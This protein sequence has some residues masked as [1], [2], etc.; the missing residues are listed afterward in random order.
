LGFPEIFVFRDP[1]G[2][3]LHRGGMKAAVVDASVNFALQE[4][5][6]LKYAKVFGNGRER[7]AEGRC[8]F[9]DHGLATRETRENGSTRGV[10]QRTKSRIQ[11]RFRIINHMV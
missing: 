8:Q 6:G 7:H 2:G 9:R 1:G 4:P 5:G 3:G 11:R 10:C